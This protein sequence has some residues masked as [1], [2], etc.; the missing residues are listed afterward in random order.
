M[1]QPTN[2]ELVDQMAS[3]FG[4]MGA[5][6]AEVGNSIAEADL[7]MQIKHLANFIQPVLQAPN[8]VQQQ[9]ES[10]PE[11]FPDMVRQSSTPVSQIVNM[12]RLGWKRVTFDFDMEISAHTS[13]EKETGV[14]SGV[15]AGASAGWGP[16]SGHVSMHCDVS[17]S[18]K[19]TRSTDLGARIKM[20][21]EL[22]RLPA[23]EGL[24][25][26]VDA[27][28]K[29]SKTAN[30][31]RLRIA[32]ARASEMFEQIGAGDVPAEALAVVEA[33]EKAAGEGD[34]GGEPAA[35]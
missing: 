11:G 17:H 1:D 24:L 3:G 25:S 10:M 13:H 19:Q 34:G 32:M 35:E 14:D 22:E 16:V 12:E 20:H 26:A 31:I 21:G 7:Q 8:V 23:S 4:T 6:I 28:N 9:I 27:A 2:T 18:D 5:K 30:E 15:E 33:E 29:F